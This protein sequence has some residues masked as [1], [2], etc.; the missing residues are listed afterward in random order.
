METKLVVNG[1]CEMSFGDGHW[2]DLLWGRFMRKTNVRLSL[3]QG[4]V[5][6]T[7]GLEHKESVIE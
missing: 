7:Q 3:C 6:V 5:D 1:I 4:I 2:L